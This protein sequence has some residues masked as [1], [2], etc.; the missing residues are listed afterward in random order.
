MWQVAIR[1]WAVHSAAPRTFGWTMSRK[2][3]VD[4]L[5]RG[6]FRHAGVFNQKQLLRRFHPETQYR[7]ADGLARQR[8]PDPMEMKWGDRSGGS[9]FPRST[10]LLLAEDSITSDAGS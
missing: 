4:R 3:L 5:S 2:V 7:L 9:E 8:S 10:A 6:R 1:A